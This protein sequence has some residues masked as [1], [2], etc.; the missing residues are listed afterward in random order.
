MNP[1]TTVINAENHP[2]GQ[3]PSL[4]VHG[5]L[6]WRAVDAGDAVMF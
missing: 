3:R 1:P 4:V 5:L 6:P 2:N